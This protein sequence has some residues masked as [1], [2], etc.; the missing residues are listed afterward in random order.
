ML[1]E[2]AHSLTIPE[3][4]VPMRFLAILVIVETIIFVIRKRQRLPYPALWTGL[5]SALLVAI[6]R[7]A[8]A[9]VFIYTNI[10]AWLWVHNV[11]LLAV[12][13]IMRLAAWTIVSKFEEQKTKVDELEQR[14]K[15]ALER[16]ETVL[17]EKSG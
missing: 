12:P 6:A 8:S 17:R 2:Q 3:A 16:F 5:I 15:G 13:V 10:E 1:S 7:S 4:Q 14:S 11:T 9:I